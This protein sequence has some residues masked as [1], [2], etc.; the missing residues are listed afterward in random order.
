L[1]VLD[2]DER[3][4]GDIEDKGITGKIVF[5]DKNVSGIGKILRC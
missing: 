1:F 4:K 3:E 5:D 2:R